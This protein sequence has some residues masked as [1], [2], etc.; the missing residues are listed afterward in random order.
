MGL[1]V[2]TYALTDLSWMI[3]YMPQSRLN[4]RSAFNAYSWIYLVSFGIT[5][6]M[7]GLSSYLQ[8]L[9]A[10]NFIEEIN[11]SPTPSPNHLHICFVCAKIS[12]YVY[13]KLKKYYMTRNVTV[14]TKK[15][16]TRSFS[17]TAC[18]QFAW[19]RTTTRRGLT[20]ATPFASVA[21]EVGAASSLRALSERTPNYVDGDD[22]RFD[23]PRLF[24]FNVDQTLLNHEMFE[25]VCDV[26]VFVQ[27]IIS[28]WIPCIVWV[29]STA[30]LSGL[31]F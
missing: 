2:C 20:A 5:S 11:F 8:A 26:I 31:D 7:T 25:I 22:L 12:N 18:A 29:Y 3:L 27:M 1:M 23:T 21:S 15:I 24:N 10:M 4:I 14:E 6:F 19:V 13:W 16:K 9:H 28:V 17:T 30:W